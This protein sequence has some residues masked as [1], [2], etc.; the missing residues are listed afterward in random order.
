VLE[1]GLGAADRPLAEVEPAFARVAW[2][3]APFNYPVLALLFDAAV[4][5]ASPSL[6]AWKL[7]LSLLE[8]LS[9]LLVARGSGSRWLGLAYFALPNSLWWTSHDGQFEALQNALALGAV[10]LAGRRRRAAWVLLA[11]AVQAKLSALL[12][13]PWLLGESARGA[14]PRA[15]AAD[16]AAFAAGFAPT[17]AAA[18]ALSP[19]RN[20]ARS[21]GL[22]ANLWYLHPTQRLEWTTHP[23]WEVVA[24]QVASWTLL[25]LLV[26]ALGRRRA[27]ALELFAPIAFL[28]ALKVAWTAQPWYLLALASFALAV[29]DA[30]LRWLL[31]LSLPLLDVGATA[32][33]LGFPTAPGL[34]D[35]HSGLSATTDLRAHY[36]R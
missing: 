2:S 28:L 6:F 35:Y 12:L 32:S 29:R 9:A 5:R 24:D 1:H 4:M 8:A 7:A 36:L 23:G 30:R 33:L 20:L 26:L 10:Y 21:G 19:L 15:L 16:L 31:F 3:G 14:R 27:G 22:P 34:G 17:L 25:G 18:F 13:V 11:L